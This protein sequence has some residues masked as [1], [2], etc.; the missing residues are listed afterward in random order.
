LLSIEKTISAKAT[1]WEQPTRGGGLINLLVQA[2]YKVAAGTVMPSLT[3]P[4]HLFGNDRDL[5]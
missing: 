4:K 5:P 1:T 3:R 2:T